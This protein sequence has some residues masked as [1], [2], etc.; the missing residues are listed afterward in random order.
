MSK[1][2]PFTQPLCSGLQGLG[3]ESHFQKLLPRLVALHISNTHRLVLAHLNFQN[4][5]LMWTAHPNFTALA[6]IIFLWCFHRDVGR[7][8]AA[9]VV[10]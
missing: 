2:K 1:G 7:N 8:S 10:A 5:T 6:I 9:G 4:A 3:M